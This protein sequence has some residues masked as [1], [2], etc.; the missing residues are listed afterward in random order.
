M[1]ETR[2]LC[3]L[4]EIPDGGSRGFDGPTN[5]HIGLFAIRK[6]AVVRVY[7]N[8]CPH[9]GIPLELVKDRFMDRKAETIICF[10][11]GA[12]FRIEDGLCTSGPCQGDALEMVP[13]SLDDEGQVLIPAAAG[14]CG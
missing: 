3:R 11:H 7:I 2:V 13:A 14:F 1:T 4:E 5:R 8:S 9:I 6:G 12:R 10:T